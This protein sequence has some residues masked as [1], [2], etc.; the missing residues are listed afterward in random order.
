MR[1]TCTSDA[2][3][4]WS[5]IKPSRRFVHDFNSVVSSI[6]LWR[7]FVKSSFPFHAAARNV[8]CAHYCWKRNKMMISRRDCY[9]TGISRTVAQYSLNRAHYALPNDM[10]ILSLFYVIALAMHVQSEH[11]RWFSPARTFV[12]PRVMHQRKSHFYLH[13]SKESCD[14]KWQLCV[15]R[16]NGRLLRKKVNDKRWL[17][18]RNSVRPYHGVYAANVMIS[19]YGL[20]FN[21]ISHLCRRFIYIASHIL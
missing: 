11:F 14:K 10:Y 13:E 2:Q 19:F 16:M 20:H 3:H 7:N 6:L 15:D 8:N 12:S 1:N 17:L 21:K 9:A 4:L 5:I 18:L